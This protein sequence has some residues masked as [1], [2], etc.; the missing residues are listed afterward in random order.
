MSNRSVALGASQSHCVLNKLPGGAGR[1]FRYHVQGDAASWACCSS[2]STCTKTHTEHVSKAGCCLSNR[3][4][5][6][7]SQSV[8]RH[9]TLLCVT[10]SQSAI[11]CLCHHAMSPRLVTLVTLM[12]ID[13][14]MTPGQVTVD[15]ANVNSKLTMLPVNAA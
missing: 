6:L 15:K 7:V 4:S 12:C 3:L 13:T 14:G 5:I 2:C 9:I 11:T 8:C 10:R 1:C